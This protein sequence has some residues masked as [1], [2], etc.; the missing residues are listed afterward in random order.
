MLSRNFSSICITFTDLIP[1]KMTLIE[2]TA[3]SHLK[4]EPDWTSILLICDLIRQNDVRYEN[5]L[6]TITGC[7]L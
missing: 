2:E 3:T 6:K 4:L 1:L 7:Q 5:I